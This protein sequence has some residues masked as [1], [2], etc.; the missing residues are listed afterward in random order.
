MHVSSH[1]G[2]RSSPEVFLEKMTTLLIVPV[3]GIF[4]KGVRAG[5]RLNRSESVTTARERSLAGFVARNGGES[6]VAVVGSSDEGAVG[7]RPFSW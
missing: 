6:A 4:L 7:L 1:L 3:V 5:N 2:W